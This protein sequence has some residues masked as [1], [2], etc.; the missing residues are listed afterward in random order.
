[1]SLRLQKGAPDVSECLV[2]G[3]NLD[4]TSAPRVE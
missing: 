2:A 1:M 4:R 3:V